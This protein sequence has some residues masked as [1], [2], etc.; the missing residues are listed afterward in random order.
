[1]CPE[2]TLS[3]LVQACKSL[4]LLNCSKRSEQFL[5]TEC[6]F[7][8]VLEVSQICIIIQKNSNWKKIIGI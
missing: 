8:L 1:M 2:T 3:N 7:N 6:F 4:N 5:V